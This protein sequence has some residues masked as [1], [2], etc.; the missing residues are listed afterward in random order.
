MVAVVAMMVAATFGTS[1]PAAAGLSDGGGPRAMQPSPTP[2]ES[3]SPSPTA[4]PTPTP[5]PAYRRVDLSVSPRRGSV[6]RR[7]VMSGSVSANRPDCSVAAAVTIRRLIFGTSRSLPVARVTTD[8]S[9]A[10]RASERARWSSAYT[11]VAQRERGCRKE[12]SDPVA[13][14]ASVRFSIRVSDLHP[15]RFANF[16]V[17]GQV[18][19]NHPRTEVL[20]QQRK[21]DRWVTVQRQELSGRSSYSFFPVAGWRGK[22]DIRVKWVKADPDHEAG[23]S[24]SFSVRTQ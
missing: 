3:A 17:H 9:G 16:R 19:P 18:R 20:L 4:S 2:T 8:Q 23:T 14:Y 10:F 22:R 5:D 21:R 15:E 6:G 11:A 1:L 12:V 7:I 24:R 13:V